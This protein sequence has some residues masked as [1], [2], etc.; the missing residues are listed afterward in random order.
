MADFANYYESVNFVFITILI[1]NFKEL[2]A[3]A[4]KTEKIFILQILGKVTISL[5][6]IPVIAAD[7]DWHIIFSPCG[8]PCH[9]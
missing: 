2:M 4:S 7:S 6:H 9:L 3:A 1:D 8:K 5:V